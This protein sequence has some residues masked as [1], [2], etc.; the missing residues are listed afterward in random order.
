MLPA[1]IRSK[2][3]YIHKTCMCF[4]V[5]VSHM[6]SYYAAFYVSSVGGGS[7]TKTTHSFPQKNVRKKLHSH[8]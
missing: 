2:Y 5:C 8:V 6:H 1:K 4:I 3:M 7:S